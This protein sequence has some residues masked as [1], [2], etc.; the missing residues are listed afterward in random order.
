MSE[1]AARENVVTVSVVEISGHFLS[2][3]E[4]C[5]LRFLC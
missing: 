5:K 4:P 2:D 3:G 1:I